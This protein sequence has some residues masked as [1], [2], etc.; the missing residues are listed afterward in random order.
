MFL[1]THLSIIKIL[2]KCNNLTN[3]LGNDGDT[4][5]ISQVKLSP[6]LDM[7][8]LSEKLFDAKSNLSIISLNAQSI[9]QSLTNIKSQ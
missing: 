1:L 6:Y 8:E 9:M 7:H 4:E 2:Q 3:L 5:E